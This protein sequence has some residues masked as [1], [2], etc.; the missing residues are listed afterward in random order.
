MSLLHVAVIGLS[1]GEYHLV[2]VLQS[3]AEVT[4]IC[5][6][7][8]DTLQRVGDKHGIPAGRRFTDYRLLIDSPEIDAVLIVVPDQ[9]HRTMCEEFLSAG[10]H[11]MCEKPLA[12]THADVS[13]IV[14]A[15]NACDRV[16]MVGQICRFTPAF[17]KAKELI[18]AGTIGELYF[19][20]SEYVLY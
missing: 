19:V 16:F 6:T 9:L 13:A 3:G 18:D 4:A 10:K 15:A 11:V 14:S 12:L 8:P 5:D 2:S 17:K 1:M 7:N 20:E